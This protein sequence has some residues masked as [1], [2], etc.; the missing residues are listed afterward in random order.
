MSCTACTRA[1]QNVETIVPNSTPL[2]VVHTCR[3]AREESEVSSGACRRRRGGCS[4][5]AVCPRLDVASL[6]GDLQYTSSLPPAAGCG[7]DWR[8]TVCLERGSGRVLLDPVLLLLRLRGCKIGAPKA[9]S[10]AAQL[11]C[12]CGSQTRLMGH[13]SSPSS[14]SSSSWPAPRYPRC[15]HFPASSFPSSPSS[16][17]SSPS[18][19]SY[20]HR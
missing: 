8:G 7:V 2:E 20:P 4:P 14:S 19:P 10:C 18:S 1:H 13:L 5:R 16:L 17:S 12:G 9:A 3:T 6:L 11:S 15:P